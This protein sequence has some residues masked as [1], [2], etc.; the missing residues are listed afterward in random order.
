MMTLNRHTQLVVMHKNSRTANNNGRLLRA[1]LCNQHLADIIFKRI[2]K[3]INNKADIRNGSYSQANRKNDVVVAIPQDWTD[4]TEQAK[5]GIVYYSQRLPV[6]LKAIG[7]RQRLWYTISNGRFVTEADFTFFDKILAQAQGDVIAVN[8]VPQLR[9]SYENARIDS[10]GRL[11]GFRRIYHDLAWPEPLPDDWPHYLFIKTAALEKIIE[12]DSLPILFS[13]FIDS[14]SSDSLVVRSLNIGGNVLD[15][16]TEAGLLGLLAAGSAKNHRRSRNNQRNSLDKQNIRIST[17]T[18]LFGKVLFGRNISIGR[19]AIIVGPAVIGDDVKIEKGVVI[20][21]SIIGNG[22]SLPCNHVVQNC[23]LIDSPSKNRLKGRENSQTRHN[24]YRQ[25]E[26]ICKPAG[27]LSTD[28]FRIWPGL[29][30]AGCV[31][32]IADIFAGAVVLLLFAP[33]FPLIALVIK[34]TSPGPVF[35]K[36]TRQGLHGKTFKCLK[37][38]TMLVGSSGMQDKLRQLNQIDGPQFMMTNDPRLSP[39]GK[40]LRD[41]YLDELPQFL[42][43]L[44][45]QMSVIGPRPSPES[46]NTLCPYWRDARL[47]VRPGIT[48]LWQI[49][50][51]RLPGRDFQEWIYYD[52]KYI[53]E[54]SL[55]MDLWICWKTIVHMVKS[56]AAWF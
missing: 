9:A 39:V 33:V 27:S 1:A 19:N 35:F 28:N 56:F 52:T 50:R 41:T 38:R 44:L 23:V 8:I 7:R 30:Y 53:R 17:G 51:T 43:V 54:L 5:S 18:R 40:F 26:N 24:K 13:E 22:V 10:N 6:S 3:S 36:H 37:F 32:R 55:K 15:L 21:A 20:R 42:N 45:G 4:R 12:D 34:L 31:K 2:K 29:S 16:E 48:G 11:V 14:C 47:S 49:C 25:T 46:E